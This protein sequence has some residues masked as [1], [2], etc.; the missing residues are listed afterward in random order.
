MGT[1]ISKD[2]RRISF[3]NTISMNPILIKKSITDS[4]EIAVEDFDDIQFSKLNFKDSTDYI[5]MHDEEQDYWTKRIDH[6]KNEH[7]V[8]NN[9]IEN[10]YKVSI[11]KTDKLFE[12]QNI[13][14]ERIHKL[15]P[16][17]D[18]RSK[19]VRCYEDNPRQPLVCSA[20]V[21]AF[22]E[23]VATCQLEN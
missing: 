16:C 17:L 3:D 18:W 15:K 19:I 23:C 2:T 9:I 8:I 13:V 10:E 1:I 22:N 21:Q 11:E 5:R 20:V 6:L 14:H 7:Q 4:D 12:K